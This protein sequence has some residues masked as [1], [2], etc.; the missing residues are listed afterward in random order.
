MQF[1]RLSR[2]G[3]CELAR[4]HREV[5]PMLKTAF[6]ELVGVEAPIQLSGMGSVGGP[7]LAA[8]VSE[9][10]GLG[11][12]TVAGLKPDEVE[13]RI[14]LIR[15]R[16]RKPFGLNFL[17]PV[18]D[19]DAVAL[20]GRGCRVVDFF[21]GD[22]TPDL[23]GIAHEGGALVSWQVGSLGEALAA[24][25][26]GC[27][28]I[29][30]QGIEAGGHIRGELGVLQLLA[31]VVEAVDVPVLAAGGIGNARMLAGIIAA[32]A[33]GARMGTRF[34]AAEETNAHPD[35]VKAL[36]E[37]RAE[38]S[39]RTSQFHVNCVLCPSTHAVL[40]SAI[41]AAEAL[42]K[43][44][45]GEWSGVRPIPRFAGAPPNRQFVGEIGAMACYAGQSVGDV[46]RVQPAAEIIQELVEGAESILRVGRS[47]M[48]TA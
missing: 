34:L 31:Q 7:E 19:V 47:Q 48:Q 9:G 2:G 45:V 36:I 27:D 1:D 4:S 24:A 5:E 30:A 11:I 38:D 41:R 15:S 25:D 17:I 26:A 3:S 20:A 33:A 6:T 39:V 12:T 23:V 37:A 43:E 40:R 14:A 29:I 16:T 32:G 42:N 22:P 13:A 10:G 44:T 21:W 28:F 18:V 8:A 35:Y 46:T